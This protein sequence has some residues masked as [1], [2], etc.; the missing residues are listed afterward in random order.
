MKKILIFICCSIVSLTC[1]QTNISAQENFPVLRS[2]N[3]LVIHLND[4]RILYEK[5]SDQQIYPASMTKIMTTL[6]AIENIKDINQTYTFTDKIF[7]ELEET[8]ASIAGFSVG[9]T[10][11]MND[12]LYGILLPS[13][14]DAT[15]A[16]A[17]VLFGSEQQFVEKMNEKAKSLKMKNT[18]FVNTSGLHNDEHYSTL[19]DM[20]K[21]LKEA[22]KN[23]KFKAI[24]ETKEYV[25]EDNSITLYSTLVKQANKTPQDTSMISGSKTGYTIEASQCLASYAKK[26]DDEFIMISAQTNSDSSYPYHIEDAGKMYEYIFANY[27]RQIVIKKGETINSI[28]VL[29]GKD[30]EYEIKADKDISVFVKNGT[31]LK[32]TWSGVKMI[33]APKTKNTYVGVYNI[34]DGKTLMTSQ[35]YTLTKDIEKK[36]EFLVSFIEVMFENW[37]VSGIIITLSGFFLIFYIKNKNKEKR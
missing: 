4:D 15:L 32:K 3:A 9:Q 23:E 8:G 34:Y 12:L 10:V 16:I 37:I 28:K 20:A 29:M 25:L 27:E 36:P 7:V 33:E 14:A 26:G 30:K 17:D 31:K 1:F 5:E 24:F 35:K 11:T 21:L 18:H 22:L 19:K 6:V 13:G 2:E